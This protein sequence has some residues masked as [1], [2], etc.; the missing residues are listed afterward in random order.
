M[1]KRLEI[2]NF[3][4]HEHTIFDDFSQGFNLICGQSDVG[5]SS[6]IRAIKLVAY[7]EFKPGMVRA[8]AKFCEVFL[9][10]ERGTVY[11]KR[12]KTINYWEVTPNGKKK[13]E[14]TSPGKAI[15]DDVASI[16]GLNVVRLG[17]IELKANVMDQL[18]GHFMMAEI[19]GTAASGSLRAQI[20]D[21]ISGISGIEQLIK[22]VSL[23][24]LRL[25]KEIKNLDDSNSEL[26]QKLHDENELKA[27]ADT[28]RIAEALLREY[29]ERQCQIAEKGEL[30]CVYSDLQGSTETLQKQLKQLHSKEQ[31]DDIATLL[32]KCE[33]NALISDDARKFFKDFH[34]LYKY[35]EGLKAQKNELPNIDGLEV[36]L[37]EASDK[38]SLVKELHSILQDATSLVRLII[39]QETQLAAL[40]VMDGLVAEID[41]TEETIAALRGMKAIAETHS[42][43]LDT[44]K[45]SEASLKE[46]PDVRAVSLIISIVEDKLPK[47]SAFKKIHSEA[48]RIKKEITSSEV[49]LDNMNVEYEQYRKEE[50]DIMSQYETCPFCQQNIIK[51]EEYE[52]VSGEGH[53]CRSGK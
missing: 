16:I 26:K 34:T 29:Q 50:S 52:T 38:F 22:D 1:I 19:D 46:L 30:Y 39:G 6:A 3:E 44:L 49:K 45:E 4:N 25:T 31:I 11:A 37:Q 40:P 23:D 17:E 47:I 20:V 18:E 42:Q 5:K 36:A 24:N 12:S 21:E 14:Y 32:V 43:H 53:S 41:K 28:L 8:G 2:K 10:T 13:T 7:N 9:T 15:L 33:K 51:G 48:E 27:E 35:K